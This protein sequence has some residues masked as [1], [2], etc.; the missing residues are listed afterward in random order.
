[1]AKH[2]ISELL[3]KNTFLENTI[4]QLEGQLQESKRIYDNLFRTLQSTIPLFPVIT[5]YQTDWSTRT[6]RS[7]TP[8][9]C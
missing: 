5:R 8:R 2:Q 3:I 4:K 9:S 6:T 1:M 7:R